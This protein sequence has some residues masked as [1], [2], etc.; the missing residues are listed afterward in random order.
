MSGKAPITMNSSRRG[1]IPLAVALL[2]LCALT[3]SA[4]AVTITPVGTA[5]S[6]S[7]TNGT[8]AYGVATY[9][10]QTTT[11]TGT[12][13]NPASASLDVTLAFTNCKLGG[14]TMIATCSGTARFAA[15]GA[16]TSGAFDLNSDFTCTFV[17]PGTCNFDVEGPQ[18]TG[19]TS[20]LNEATTVLTLTLTVA[21]T[22]TGAGSCGPA[23]G[24]S[25]W[26]MSFTITPTT[27]A[28]T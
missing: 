6:W 22:R 12:T 8:L 15:S 4:H 21:M 2:T 24:T 13:T 19:N 20:T 9:T 14:L 10:C 18:T 25:S 5:T 26:S 28:I 3:S 1:T 7:A 11:A 27:L 17:V 16:A 23:S